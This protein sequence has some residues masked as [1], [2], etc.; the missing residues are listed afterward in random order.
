M[1]E[2]EFFISFGIQ[3]KTYIG[4]SYDDDY[5]DRCHCYAIEGCNNCSYKTEKQ[6]LNPYPKI[7]DNIILKLIDELSEY[8]VLSIKQEWKTTVVMYETNDNNYYCSSNKYLKNCILQICIDANEETGLRV[9]EI[10]NI[11]E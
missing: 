1:L 11:G 2:K 5:M 10:F 6:S 3:P 7:T 4:C 8:G 9:K